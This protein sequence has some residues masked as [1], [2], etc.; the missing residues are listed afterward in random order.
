[1]LQF[2]YEGD[3]FAVPSKARYEGNEST[4]SAECNRDGQNPQSSLTATAQSQADQASLTSDEARIHV[5]VYEFAGHFQMPKLKLLALENFKRVKCSLT[6]DDFLDLAEFVY[7]SAQTVNHDLQDEL[8]TFL[9]EE[10]PEWLAIP[11]FANT[12]ASDP[13]LSLLNGATLGT[14]AEKLMKCANQETEARSLRKRFF[15][16]EVD[17]RKEKARDTET[18]AFKAKVS[19][20]EAKCINASDTIQ[21]LKAELKTVRAELKTTKD[22]ANKCHEQWNANHKAFQESEKKLQ[23]EKEIASAKTFELESER[24]RADRAVNVVKQIV[25]VANRIRECNNCGMQQMFRLLKDSRATGYP[26]GSI[27]LCTNCNERHYGQVV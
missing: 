21:D 18:D 24:E 22:R 8:Y 25:S 14:L 13:G 26:V 9:T 17:L 10:H 4:D 19:E 27:V 11:S 5:L 20:L 12:L 23:Q 7:S 16:L 1:M 3:Y 6:A 2:M 15:Q